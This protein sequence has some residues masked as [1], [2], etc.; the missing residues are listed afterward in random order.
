MLSVWIGCSSQNRLE[1][2][3]VEGTSK[4]WFIVST[5][6]LRGEPHATKPMSVASC[7]VLKYIYIFSLPQLSGI[8][9]LGIMIHFT[10]EITEARNGEEGL[11]QADWGLGLPFGG[12]VSWVVE[13][14]TTA[15]DHWK[16]SLRPLRHPMGRCSRSQGLESPAGSDHCSGV[17]H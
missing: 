3:L 2:L 6:Q 13:P 15:K 8:N 12:A 17:I 1:K 7:L 11:L 16:S 4:R 10:G 9:C 5:S 14:N